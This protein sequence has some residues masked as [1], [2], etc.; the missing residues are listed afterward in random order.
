MKEVD[1]VETPRT[2]IYWSLLASISAV[3]SPNLYYKKKAYDLKPNIFVLMIGRSGLGKGFGAKIA[4]KLVEGVGNTRIISGTGTIEGMI[5]DLSIVKAKPDGTIPF[6]DA[7]GFLVSGE[8]AASFYDSSRALTALTDL[9]DC[10]YHKQWNN[11]LKNSPVEILRDPC[12]TLLSGANQDMFDLAV[13]KTHRGGGFIGRT[14]LISSD[15]RA[16]ANSMIRFQDDEPEID[17]AKH[18]C[19]LKD[20]AKLSGRMVMSDTAM[21]TYDEW[22]YPYRNAEVDDRTG[23]NDRL[24]D[25]VIKVAMCL[26]LSHNKDLIIEEDDISEAIELCSGLSN[27]ARNVAGMQTQSSIAEHCKVFLRIMLESTGYELTRKQTLQKG[28]GSF[29]AV[30]LDKVVETMT[31]TGYVFQSQG[32]KDI[33]YKLTQKCIEYFTKEKK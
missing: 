25:H 17:Y 33:K 27:T 26:A 16:K 19:Y 3:V 22:F 10:H 11:T 24:N 28:F 15:K 20:L 4:S 9:Y 29:D 31:Q 12:L 30:E 14:F 21:D 7:R 1:F 5:K 32:G 8:F 2:W 23:T 13:D 6:K 18:I